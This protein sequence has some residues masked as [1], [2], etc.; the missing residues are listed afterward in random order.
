MIAA[1][2]GVTCVAQW[3]GLPLAARVP[4]PLPMTALIALSLAWLALLARIRDADRPAGDPQDMLPP[5]RD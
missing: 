1:G 4:V 5:H 3:L 2:A